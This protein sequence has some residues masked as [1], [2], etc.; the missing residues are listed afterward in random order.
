MKNTT[1]PLYLEEAAMDYF[2]DGRFQF[3]CFF[4]NIK[5]LCKKFKNLLISP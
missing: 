5:E 2:S 1:L 3:G 4:I